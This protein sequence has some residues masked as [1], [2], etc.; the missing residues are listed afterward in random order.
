[1]SALA[2]LVARSRRVV[3]L[4]GAGISTSSG[5]P[6][7]RGPGGRWRERDPMTVAHIDTYR[8]DPVLLW[9]YYGE[10]YER[11][12]PA[13]PTIAHRILAGWQTAGV[14]ADLFTQNIDDLHERAGSVAHHLHGEIAVAECLEC[15]RRTTMEAALAS[16]A[17]APD[18]V[19]RCP[20]DGTVLKP[21]I[22]LFGEILGHEIELAIRAACVCDLLLVVGSSLV[23]YPVSS[24]PQVAHAAG[25]Q[26]AIVTASETEWDDLCAVREFGDID[27]VLAAAAAAL[28]GD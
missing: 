25:A 3:V 10:V 15:G 16:R 18:G 1:V 14:V 22:V 19:P 2:E 13:Q 21:A 7:Y 27:A 20:E 9:D 5:I 6:D 4:T 24:L 26:I 23:V 28:E 17:G 12:A 11:M 8:G